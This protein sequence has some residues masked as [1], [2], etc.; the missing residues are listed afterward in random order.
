M[1]SGGDSKGEGRG[2]VGGAQRWEGRVE[3]GSGYEVGSVSRGVDG[4]IEGRGG[5]CSVHDK[6]APFNGGRGWGRPGQDCPGYLTRWKLRQVAEWRDPHLV[7]QVN[8]RLGR[9]R[10]ILV[11]AV[12]V[13][14]PEI[15]FSP[16]LSRS[17]DQ[18]PLDSL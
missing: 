1:C 7:R 4:H 16:N 17:E 2:T 12:V 18:A 15:S 9:R 13:C 10:R 8:V 3:R 11:V 14:W 5:Q 6:K